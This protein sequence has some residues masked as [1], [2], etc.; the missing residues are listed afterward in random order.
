M[1]SEGLAPRF[2]IQV[3]L[4]DKILPM[5]GFIHDLLGGAVYGMIEGLKGYEDT[6]SIEIKVERRRSGGDVS[7]PD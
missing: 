5:K 7:T 2:R 3:K 1:N 6:D 4:G